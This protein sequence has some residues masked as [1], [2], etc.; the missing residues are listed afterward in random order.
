MLG[1]QP[2]ALEVL[3]SGCLGPTD[4]LPSAAAARKMGQVCPVP[5]TSGQLSARKDLKV[6][7]TCEERTSVGSLDSPCQAPALC[8]ALGWCWGH[9][10]QGDGGEVGGGGSDSD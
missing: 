2:P 3:P 5:L 7:L 4:F 8:Q 1:S 6:H 10:G 9:S